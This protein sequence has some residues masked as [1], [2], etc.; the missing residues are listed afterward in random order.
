[1]DAVDKLISLSLVY[2]EKTKESVYVNLNNVK[3]DIKK[4][5]NEGI[6]VSVITFYIN[7]MQIVTTITEVSKDCPIVNISIYNYLP[8]FEHLL[9]D[10][11]EKHELNKS[12]IN[13]ILNF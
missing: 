1:M 2:N 5:F 6:S 11:I 13:Q 9:I 12:K 4:I 3:F 8:D 7:N 10:T